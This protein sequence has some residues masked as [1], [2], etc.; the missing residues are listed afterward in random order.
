MSG[1]SKYHEIRTFSIIFGKPGF[2]ADTLLI[3]ALP[4]CRGFW[5]FPL[6]VLSFSPNWWSHSGDPEDLARPVTPRLLMHAPKARCMM[7]G[8]H[9]IWFLNAGHWIAEASSVYCSSRVIESFEEVLSVVIPS[10][11]QSV[12]SKQSSMPFKCTATLPRVCWPLIYH[13]ELVFETGIEQAINLIESELNY[14]YY[15][16][17]IHIVSNA[18]CYGLFVRWCPSIQS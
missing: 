18:R 5:L 14:I 2:M 9:G 12:H 15:P 6:F 16:I 4:S 1:L 8:M 7:S 10:K 13:S 3:D 11:W 17:S